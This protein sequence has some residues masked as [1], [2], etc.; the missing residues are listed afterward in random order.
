MLLCNKPSGSSGYL[1]KGF[2]KK[3]KNCQIRIDNRGFKCQK[4]CTIIL[5]LTSPGKQ[6]N[7]PLAA[8][9]QLVNFYLWLYLWI[10]INVFFLL[11]A[12]RF[13]LLVPDPVQVSTT[14]HKTDCDDSG[15]AW[16][17]QRAAG[18][19]AWQCAEILC[20]DYEQENWLFL[21]VSKSDIFS[22]Q[23]PKKGIKNMSLMGKTCSRKLI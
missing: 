23:M 5:I 10:S 12:Q 11:V 21:T 1:S 13:Y 7:C 9:L 14:N 15:K 22:S 8:R 17:K 2:Y 3:K 20:P 18:Q 6:N 4:Y 19:N 16:Q